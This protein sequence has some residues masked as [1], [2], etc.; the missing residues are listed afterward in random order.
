MFTKNSLIKNIFEEEKSLIVEHY[1][2]GKIASYLDQG[3]DWKL[4]MELSE[5]V[6][7]PDNQA[8]KN[9][10]TEAILKVKNDHRS[11]F[12]NF[13]VARLDFLGGTPPTF[14]H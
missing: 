7:Y 12:S 9:E 5:K 3:E 2:F 11:K 1:F 6:Q 4:T 8:I 10:L 14:E 13:K